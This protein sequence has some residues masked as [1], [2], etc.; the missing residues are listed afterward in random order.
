[1]KPIINTMYFAFIGIGGNNNMISILGKL[2]PK[3]SIFHR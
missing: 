1:M 2:I 3:P